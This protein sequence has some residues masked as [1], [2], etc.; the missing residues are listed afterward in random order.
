MPYIP[1]TLAPTSSIDPSMVPRAPITE[2]KAQVPLNNDNAK[3]YSRK[4]NPFMSK[5][6]MY[7]WDVDP[8]KVYKQLT[9]KDLNVDEHTGLVSNS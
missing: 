9:K 8:L 4:T 5:L 2:R 6:N 7:K 3:I 1:R